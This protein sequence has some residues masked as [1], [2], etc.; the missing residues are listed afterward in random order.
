MSTIRKRGHVIFSCDECGEEY[1]SMTGDFHDALGDAKSD[2]WEARQEDGEWH[3][4]CG[5]CQ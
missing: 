2:G 5:D 3:H 4:Y 1:D